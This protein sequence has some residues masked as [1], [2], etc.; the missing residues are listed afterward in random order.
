[1]VFFLSPSLSLSLSVASAVLL[2]HFCFFICF[3]LSRFIWFSFVVYCDED[4]WTPSS[5][6]RTW[7]QAMNGTMTNSNNADALLNGRVNVNERAERMG[8]M[9]MHHDEILNEMPNKVFHHFK[10]DQMWKN[11]KILRWRHSR[12]ISFM[13]CATY[14]RISFR[15]DAL[16]CTVYADKMNRT[17]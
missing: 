7:F 11:G 4:Q 9:R 10:S 14:E 5:L 12:W 15:L 13:W 16:H 3:S 2:K 8:A 1:M 6:N 17:F